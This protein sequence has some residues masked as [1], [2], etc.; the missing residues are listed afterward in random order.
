MGIRDGIMRVVVGSW[1]VVGGVDG[2]GADEVAIGAEG[3]RRVHAKGRNRGYDVRK[4]DMDVIILSGVH[5]CRLATTQ[6][7]RRYGIQ[8]ELFLYKQMSQNAIVC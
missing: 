7:T 5:V 8:K 4:W 1:D 6:D 2:G 3:T